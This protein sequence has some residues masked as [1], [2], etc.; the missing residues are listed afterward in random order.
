M[1]LRNTYTVHVKTHILYSL[2]LEVPRLLKI[3]TTLRPRSFQPQIPHLLLSLTLQQ[4]IKCQN[5]S[6]FSENE[7][8]PIGLMHNCCENLSLLPLKWI[9]LEIKSITMY[10]YIYIYVCIYTYIYM[11]IYIYINIII[12]TQCGKSN[13]CFGSVLVS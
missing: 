11:Y 8:F 7:H 10:E 1:Q 6:P 13:K 2:L 5:K 4:C 12:N 9:F 3:P